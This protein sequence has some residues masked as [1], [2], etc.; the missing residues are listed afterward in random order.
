MS[1]SEIGLAVFEFPS[2]EAARTAF[3]AAYAQVEEHGRTLSVMTGLW[4]GRSVVVVGGPEMPAII[5][6][7]KWVEQQGGVQMDVTPE[8]VLP[9]AL[10]IARAVAQ[11]VTVKLDHGDDGIRL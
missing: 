2:R 6:A 10:R 4:N 5:E 9:F 11:G 3:R 1:V 8:E 7:C